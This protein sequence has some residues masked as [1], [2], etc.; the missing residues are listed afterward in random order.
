MTCSRNVV[1]D[2]LPDYWYEYRSATSLNICES[3][4]TQQRADDFV[5][6]FYDFVTNWEQI[7]MSQTAKDGKRNQWYNFTVAYLDPTGNSPNR[8]PSGLYVAPE[9]FVEGVSNGN[10]QT[11]MEKIYVLMKNYKQ[12]WNTFDKPTS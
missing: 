9:G 2:P 4:R 8:I 3:L 12:K 11:P 6:L 1:L 7:T 10:P 5:D